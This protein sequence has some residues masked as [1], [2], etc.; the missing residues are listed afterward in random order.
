MFTILLSKKRHGHL[1]SELPTQH[2]EEK[3]EDIVRNKAEH[4]LIEKAVTVT[5]LLHSSD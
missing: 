2:A 4:I 5:F 1:H 3:K